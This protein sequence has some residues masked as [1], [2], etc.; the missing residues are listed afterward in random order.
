MTQRALIIAA[1]S[2]QPRTI[3][4]ALVC[5]DS[6]R[7]SA[8][9]Q[10]LGAQIFW[11]GEVIR[12]DP[13]PLAGRGQVFDCGNAGTAARFGAALSLVTE[14]PFVIDGDQRMRERPMGP[15]VGALT[16]LG[17]NVAYLGEPDVL[18]ARFDRRSAGQRARIDS[19]SSSQFASALLLAGPCLPS[20]LQL[21]IT[22]DVVS[23]DYLRLTRLMMIASGASIAGGE[24]IDVQPGGYPAADDIAIEGDWSS[25]SFL[26]AAGWLAGQSIA[27]ENLPQTSLQGDAVFPGLLDELTAERSHHFDLRNTPDLI[28]PLAAAALFAAQPSSIRGVAHARFK[29]SDRISALA[30][31]LRKIGANIEETADGLDIEPLLRPRGAVLDPH[32]DHRLA[33]AFGVISLRIPG[34]EVL[35]PECVSKS[36][37]SFWSTLD[38]IRK[39]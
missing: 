37:P 27:I 31:E 39:G 23:A 38:L 36:F 3:R 6:E 13:A 15:L 16:Q 7:L 34:I 24:V 28:A 18:P 35:D 9:L 20:G 30:S 17:V 4:G 1:L 11:D 32:R 21:T 26:L 5:D 2:A 22:G 14:G 8:I 29:E 33:M 10:G 12:V 19:S 25:A